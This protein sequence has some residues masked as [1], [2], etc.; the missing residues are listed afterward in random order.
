MIRDR[1]VEFFQSGK[2][3]KTSNRIYI[4]I[5]YNHVLEHNHNFYFDAE[6]YLIIINKQKYKKK[7]AFTM[8]LNIMVLVIYTQI[9]SVIMF[10]LYTR[11]EY[12]IIL[13]TRFSIFI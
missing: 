10:T 8:K 9:L 11:Q 5:I 4:Y 7:F 6:M 12:I 13:N 1:L 2:I 3:H